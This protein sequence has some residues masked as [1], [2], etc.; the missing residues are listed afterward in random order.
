MTEP[1]SGA[2]IAYLF[3]EAAVDAINLGAGHVMSDSIDEA[4]LG[5]TVD[6]GGDAQST[7]TLRESAALEEATREHLWATISYNTS[8]AA[9]QHE[10]VA[11]QHRKGEIILW[12]VKH[13][14]TPGTKTKFL[15]DPLKAFLPRFERFVAR[16]VRK[17]LEA[18]GVSQGSARRVVEQLIG[19]P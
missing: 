1:L 16:Y 13:H 3:L 14:T 9:A 4:P 11:L 12:I 8:Y 10:G 7:S 19:T 18:E 17:R 5:P 6:E 15:E 2:R